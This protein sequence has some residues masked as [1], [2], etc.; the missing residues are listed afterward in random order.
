MYTISWG[1]RETVDADEDLCEQ[2]VHPSHELCEIAHT[3][4]EAEETSDADDHY[5]ILYIEYT[6]L[7]VTNFVRLPIH[8]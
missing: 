7:G 3:S 4:M 2:Y 6:K 8:Q 1:W 5:C